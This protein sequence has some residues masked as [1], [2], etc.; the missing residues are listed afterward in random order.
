MFGVLF[1]FFKSGDKKK[2][3]GGEATTKSGRGKKKKPGGKS[4]KREKQSSL[5]RNL[6]GG[7]LGGAEWQRAACKTESLRR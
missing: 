5:K 2:S 4:R 1:C 7:D 3:W 6:L